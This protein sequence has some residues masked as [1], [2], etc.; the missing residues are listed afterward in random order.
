[1]DS[2]GNK[3]VIKERLD[4]HSSYDLLYNSMLLGDNDIGDIN[5]RDLLKPGFAWKVNKYLEKKVVAKEL[6]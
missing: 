1:M 3:S 5:M 6:I 2:S 4:Q